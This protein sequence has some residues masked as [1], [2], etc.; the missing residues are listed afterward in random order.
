MSV[1]TGGKERMRRLIELV[2]GGRLNLIR[3]NM[4][5]FFHD[6][7]VDASKL[8]GGR[9]NRAIKVSSKP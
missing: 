5:T 6:E 1:I 9:L 2:R 8:F 3:L 7:I 4:H